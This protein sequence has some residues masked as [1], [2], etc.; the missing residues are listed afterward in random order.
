MKLF[1][2]TE[3]REIGNVKDLRVIVMRAECQSDVEKRFPRLPG[4]NERVIQ[5]LSPIGPASVI[6]NRMHSSSF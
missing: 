2:L 3:E 1:L 4:N 6:L 5:V